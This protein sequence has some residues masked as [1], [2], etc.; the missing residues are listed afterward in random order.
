MDVKN[1]KTVLNDNAGLYQKREEK[2]E[3][4]KFSEL[5]GKEKRTYF[6]D[7]YLKK[8]IAI[9]AAIALVIYFGYTVS[10]SRK[11]T[12]V[13]YAASA[14]YSFNTE[15]TKQ[16]EIEFGEYIGKISDY[17]DVVFDSSY[18][19]SASDYSSLEKLS[20][21]IMVGDIDV[22]I[23]PESFF[24]N[25]VFTEAISSLTEILPTDLYSS[26]TNEF[27]YGQVRQSD[28]ETLENAS[29]PV[30][31]YGIYLENTPLFS[32]Y[33]PYADPP[34][35]GIVVTSKNRENSIE[36]IRFLFEKFV[37][38]IVTE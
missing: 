4:Q 37:P 32:Q 20:T 1:K 25:Y 2:S 6:K 35:L 3:K 34:V 13:F 33:A 17:E 23:A 38:E 21:L 9:I 27:F 29:G 5:H 16:L 14:D 7:Y 26:L 10:E 31:V 12:S 11:H 18:F 24:K 28:D 19:L 30:G 15:V 8:C 22:F 36:F